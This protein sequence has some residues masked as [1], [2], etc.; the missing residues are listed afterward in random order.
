MQVPFK[1]P[2]PYQLRIALRDTASDRIGSASRFIQ[3]PD[4]KRGRLTLSGLLIEGVTDPATPSGADDRDPQS[5]VAVRTFRQGTFASYVCSVYNARRD[6]GTPQLE[7]EV[8]LYREGVEVSRSTQRGTLPV[9]GTMDPLVGGV[10]QLGD[11]TPPGS[12][13]LELTVTDTLAKQPSRATQTIDFDVI[14]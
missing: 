10:L 12:Y 13:V 14:R 8:R 7:T 1:R 2:G 11:N 6:G 3:V 9:P 5:T 4:V